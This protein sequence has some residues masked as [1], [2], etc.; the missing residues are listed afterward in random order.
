MTLF[1]GLNVRLA[2]LYGSVIR[3]HL[4]H[5]VE[6]LEQ[7]RI[8]S[9]VA[10]DRADHGAQRAGRS[11]HVEPHFHELRDDAL[12]LLVGGAL[13]HHYDHM[14]LFEPFI[15]LGPPRRTL[16]SCPGLVRD[17]L[18]SPRF[19]DDALEQPLHRRIVERSR[20]D[21][22][23]VIEHLRLAR[24]LIERPSRRASSRD[25]SRSA[26]CGAFAQQP[27][28][29]LVDRVDLAPQLVEPCSHC[30]LQPSHVF[31]CP[32]GD[33]RRRAMFRNHVHER[34]A[35]DRRVRR[36]ARLRDVF[37]RRDA[38]PER[39]GQAR[40]RSAPARRAPRRRSQGCRGRR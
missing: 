4:L 23:D 28:E 38:E 7:P 26:H 36:R 2:S 12:H 16:R 1:S 20:V 14:N 32:I 30:A 10:A 22:L 29:L 35:D 13:L 33:V 19:V 40:L 5:A 15:L 18:Q 9:A 6:H 31:A 27:D 11:M 39:D 21:L 17:P 34:A 25:R 3:K 8:R 24:R 37:G